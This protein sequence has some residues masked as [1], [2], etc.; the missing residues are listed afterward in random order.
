MHKDG[1]TADQIKHKTPFLCFRADFGNFLVLVGQPVIFLPSSGTEP[2][3]R[4]PVGARRCCS[5]VGL[6]ALTAAQGGSCPPTPAWGAHLGM[7]YM[8]KEKL[9]AIFLVREETS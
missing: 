3:S 8:M 5:S 9:A 2:T 7:P 6:W 1:R 4:K